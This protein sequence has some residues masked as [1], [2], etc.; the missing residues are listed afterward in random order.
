MSHTE[1]RAAGGRMVPKA[2]KTTVAEAS[3]HVTPHSAN[4]A[5]AF[6]S[7]S[8]PG[9]AGESFDGDPAAPGSAPSMSH[10]RTKERSGFTSHTGSVIPPFL[11][12]SEP[13]NDVEPGTLG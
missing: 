12:H 7:L 11:N 13:I 6:K 4:P 10:H 2:H 8:Q 9:Y 1:K 5:G 3:R